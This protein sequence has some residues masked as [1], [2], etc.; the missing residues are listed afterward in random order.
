[1][2][3]VDDVL[4]FWFEELKPEDWFSGAVE[5]DDAIALRFAAL[6]QAVKE[7]PPSINQFDAR[8]HLATVVV[9]DQFSRN[10]FRGR[11]E[12]FAAD[13]VA[14]T[15]AFHAIAQGLDAAM[16]MSERHF[17]YMP[18]MHAEDM[19][20]QDRSVE[21]FARLGQPDLLGYA[22]QHRAVIARFGRFPA[23]NAALGRDST[24][25][26]REYLESLTHKDAGARY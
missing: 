15:Y 5:V 16:V 9:L 19:K 22:E 23:R 24:P 21:L 1:M 6:R 12:A 2:Q 26:E 3:W 14:L 20:L 17:L 18:F 10:L 8:G 4:G 25:A 7:S 11:A 13:P